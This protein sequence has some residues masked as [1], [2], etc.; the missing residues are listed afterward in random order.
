[1]AASEES[2]R[3][4]VGHHGWEGRHWGDRAWGWVEY[5]WRESNKTYAWDPQTCDQGGDWQQ[6]QVLR[7]SEPAS[8]G[9]TPLTVGGGDGQLQNEVGWR[10]CPE[11]I[12]AVDHFLESLLK[13]NIDP[14]LLA[15]VLYGNLAHDLMGSLVQ[16]ES[17]RLVREQSSQPNPAAPATVDGLKD[18]SPPV[19]GA[20]M[21][22]PPKFPSGCRACKRPG[23]NVHF[24]PKKQ[25]HVYCCSAC[26]HGRLHS[27]GTDICRRAVMPV[28]LDAEK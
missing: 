13:H 28:L 12:G 21:P 6:E 17:K 16:E 3:S 27:S 2:W 5:G 19:D 25:S 1:M 24:F 11:L 10:Q 4:D 20:P 23:C 15:V 8:G 18:S 22:T 14:Q 7:S 26:R 9:A